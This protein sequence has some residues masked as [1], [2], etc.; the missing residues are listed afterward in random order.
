MDGGV[1]VHLLELSQ[2]VPADLAVGSHFLFPRQHSPPCTGCLL[3]APMSRGSVAT[4]EISPPGSGEHLAQACT[5][6]CLVCSAQR[7]LP[8]VLLLRTTER[9]PGQTGFKT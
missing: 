7:E 9:A 3:G 8:E 4:A 5:G 6:L 1:P 2:H